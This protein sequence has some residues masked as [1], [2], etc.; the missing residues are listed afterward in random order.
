[1]KNLLIFLAM[2]PLLLSSCKKG[3]TDKTVIDIG[4]DI[5]YKD[6]LGNDLLD[7]ATPNYFSASNIHVYHLI[8]G[9]KTEVYNPMMDSPRDFMIYKND[10]LNQYVLGVSLTANTV[11]LQLNEN[12]T[13]T[14]T[15]TIDKG[16]N[17][18]IVK[19]IWYNGVPKWEF[20]KVAPTFTITK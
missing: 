10:S 15:C 5:S 14:I 19:K 13:D 12:I 11:L 7:P 1:M 18:E 17:Y 6:N 4:V 2:I 16:D 8:N 20:G 3:T 9:V